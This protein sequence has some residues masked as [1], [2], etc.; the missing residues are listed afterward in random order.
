MCPYRGLV[1]SLFVILGFASVGHAD[2]FVIAKG[3]KY[4]PEKEQRA[5]IE[6]DDGQ[7]KLFV[8]TRTEESSEETLWI[9]P[10]PAKPDTVRADPVAKFPL[11]VASNGVVQKGREHLKGAIGY[12]V[13]ADTGFVGLPLF[14]LLGETRKGTF[15]QVLDLS[16]HQH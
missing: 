16:V 14:C 6:W 11:V 10:V 9:V 2:G 7:E 4:V 8:A 3:G 5:F 12:A 1:L 13:M 15:S